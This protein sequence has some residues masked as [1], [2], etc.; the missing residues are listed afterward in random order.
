MVGGAVDYGAL[1]FYGLRPLAGRFFDHNHGDDDR[2]LDRETAG[3]PSIVINE[4]AMRKLGFSSPSQAI[5]KIVIWNRRRWSAN[6][7]P[8]TVVSSEIIGVLPDYGLNTRRP[9]LPQIL[10]VGLNSYSVLSVRLIGSQIPEALTSIDADWSTIMRTNIHRR[11]LSQTLQDMYADVTVQ[12]TAISLGA[13]LAAAIAALGLFGLSAH[14][15]EQRTKEIGIRKVMGAGSADIVR[16]MLGEFS[17]PVLWANLI[18]W[19]AAYLIMRRW[20]EGFAYRIDMRPWMF[21]TATAIAVVIAMATV[22]GHALLA[23]RAKPVAA[24]RYE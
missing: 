21:L 24:L 11:F 14:S 1:E 17:Q 15:A 23:A 19:P 8:G 22:I 4:T 2:L 13:G 10:Y 5:G 18:A 6:P 7:N 12:G 3:S 16:L 9:V 20:L